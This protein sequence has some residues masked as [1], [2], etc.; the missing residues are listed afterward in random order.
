[1]ANGTDSIFTGAN[2]A[3]ITELYERYLENPASVDASWA[4]AFAELN[5]DADTIQK[6]VLKASGA[7][8]IDEMRDI[9]KR[10]YRDTHDL[11]ADNK[12]Y[13]N[14]LAQELLLKETLNEEDID[15]ILAI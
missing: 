7:T 12:S 11:I 5:D 10:L 2:G 6:D 15:S 4:A 1:M 3:F 8:N 13:L 9:I 14:T